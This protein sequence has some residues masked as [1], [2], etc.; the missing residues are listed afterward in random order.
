[1]RNL[2]AR[3]D[4]GLLE[5]FSHP[6]SEVGLSHNLPAGRWV[7]GSKAAGASHKAVNPNRRAWQH[8][9]AYVCGL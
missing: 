5:S 8:L 2:E 6:S 7:S 1:M 9:H 4:F 3:S